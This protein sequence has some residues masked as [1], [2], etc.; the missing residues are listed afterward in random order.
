MRSVI[1]DCGGEPSD[2][3]TVRE[4]PLPV[5]Q[6]GEVLVQM[7]ASPINP[8]DLYFI[9]GV[10]TQKP[11]YPAV[12][13][14]E[15]MGI[16]TQGTG[17]LLAKFLVGKRVAVIGGEQGHWREFT[18]AKARQ[19]IPV[20][21]DLSDEVAAMFF[22]NPATA[23]MLIESVLKVPRGGWVMQ[24]AANSALGRMVIR[25]GK[26]LGF[27]TLNLVRRDNS[28]DELRALGGDAVVAFDPERH[29]VE[30]LQQQVHQHT[31]LREIPFAMDCVGGKTGEAMLACLGRR[32]H[33]VVSGTLS[34][35]PIPLSSRQLI[36]TGARISGF[37]LSQAMQEAGLLTKLRLVRRIAKLLRAGVLTTEVSRRFSLEKVVEGIQAAEQPGRRGKILL[38]MGESPSS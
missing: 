18:V 1:F 37:W 19:V 31:G 10:Y 8:S 17:S 16:V 38:T 15:G 24:S 25:L 13:G 23:L 33:L 14:F 34:H 9:R 11:K 26:Y 35:E 4:L 30:E 22:V 12:P 32:G 20:S 2:V 3:L 27:H 7:R 6:P 28:V 29:S 5:I 21:R 36:Q